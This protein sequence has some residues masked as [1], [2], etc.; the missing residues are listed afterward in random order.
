[1]RCKQIVSLQSSREKGFS[2]KHI[3]ILILCVATEK[4]TCYE[5]VVWAN[6]KYNAT[7]NARDQEKA[8]G[9]ALLRTAM[10]RAREPGMVSRLCFQS[11]FVL[12]CTHGG[13]R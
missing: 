2:E 4:G 3:H 1:M 8:N 5:R 7:N 13:S 10:S 9:G 11:N 12:M 6:N